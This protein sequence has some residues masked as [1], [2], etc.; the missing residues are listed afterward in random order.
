MEDNIE[1]NKLILKC[2]YC[3]EFFII[4]KKELNCKIIRHGS[5]KTDY[6]QIDPHLCKEE[7]DRLLNENLIYGCGKPCE[8]IEET[9][10]YT[11]IKCEYK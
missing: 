8:I 6:K 4:Y 2:P 9:D 7:C 5:Y 3:E 11:I 10:K 1:D